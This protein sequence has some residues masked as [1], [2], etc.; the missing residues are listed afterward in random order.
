MDIAGGSRPESGA[1][2][3]A[4]PSTCGDAN[5]APEQSTNTVPPTPATRLPWSGRSR[6]PTL[7]V[8]QTSAG[9]YDGGLVLSGGDAG[10]ESNVVRAAV[11]RSDGR[12]SSVES[13]AAAPGSAV[14]SALVQ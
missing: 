5:D 13:F 14:E 4:Y 6:L 7:Q 9:V 11:R 1:E 10:P 8:P 2:L 3:H 12:P